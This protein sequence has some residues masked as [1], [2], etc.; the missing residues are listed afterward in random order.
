VTPPR[1]ALDL[2][3]A[4]FDRILA[5][6]AGQVRAHGL[7]DAVVGVLRGGM[8]PAVVLAH[9][10]GVRAVRALE[11][12][13]TLSDAPHAPKTPDPVVGEVSGL[14]ALAG[15]DVL[16]VDDVAGSGATAGPAT[17]LLRSRA[18]ARLRR[19]VAG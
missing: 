5:V 9:R 3:W 14:G 10:L 6:V 13:R 2:D 19:A 17:E 7:P 4:G 18:P 16:L 15:L 8:V 12:T 1:V 11:V